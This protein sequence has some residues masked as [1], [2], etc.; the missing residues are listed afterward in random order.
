M[1]DVAPRS[2][3]VWVVRLVS[4]S[5]SSHLQKEKILSHIQS[6]IFLKISFSAL[7]VGIQVM[8]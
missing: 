8:G 3:E 1:D 7:N 6:I 2:T 5:S 4:F